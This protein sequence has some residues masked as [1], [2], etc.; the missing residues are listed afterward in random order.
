MKRKIICIAVALAFVALPVA[1]KLSNAGAVRPAQLGKVELKQI[2]PSIL[3]TGNLVFRQEVQL[4]SEVIGRVSEV[5]VKEGDRVTRG[6]VLL[7]LDP[8]L[9]RSEVQQHEATRR[10]AQI[11][12]ERAQLNVINQQRNLDRA[13]QLA[14]AKFIDAS[15][16][17][18]ASHQMKLA[19]IQ[20]RVNEET[21]QQAQATVSLVRERLAKTEVRAPIDG[22]ATAV[23]IKIG[24][25]AVASV[26]GMPGSSLMTIADVGSIMAEVNVDEA[27]VAGV[28]AGQRARVFPSA[29]PERPLDGTVETVSLAPKVGA[30]GRSYIVKLRLDDSALALRTGMTCRV[31]IVTGGGTP[32]PVVPLQAILAEQGERDKGST[33]D[34]SASANFVLAVIDGKIRKQPVELGLADDNNREVLAGLPVGAAI[35]VG[36]A[37]TLRELR[38]GDRVA[39]PEAASGSAPASAPAVAARPAQHAARANP[40]ANLP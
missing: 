33:R 35:A 26:T 18:D 39:S 3:A 13:K 5:L 15:R 27:D 6:Q 21:L 34:R 20:A 40:R 30:Q 10:S 17:D 38:E 14:Q 36:P 8:T 32:R 29:F 12:V 1:V 28:H 7:R 4:T 25:T 19:Q 2:Q 9:Y 22:T 16:L 31:E 37:R 23:Q 11:E 24:E